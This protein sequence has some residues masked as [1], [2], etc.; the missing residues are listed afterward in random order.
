MP[1]TSLV[2]VLISL[3]LQGLTFSAPHTWSFTGLVTETRQVFVMGL[4]A[5]VARVKSI[6]F[7]AWVIQRMDSQ[8]AELGEIV[9]GEDGV[10]RKEFVGVGDLVQVSIGGAHVSE[11]GVDW[12]LCQPISSN[13][14]RQGRFY[15]DGPLSG[16]WGLPLSPSNTFIH[17]GQPN[18]STESALFWNTDVLKEAADLELETRAWQSGQVSFYLIGPDSHHDFIRHFPTGFC[19]MAGPML[20]HGCLIPQ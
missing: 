20:S 13:Y 5:Q 2:A 11:N 18:P 4:P 1:K 8:S 9:L 19:R 15:D 10:T 17:T 16:D 7:E 3:L 12:N 6:D 14:C